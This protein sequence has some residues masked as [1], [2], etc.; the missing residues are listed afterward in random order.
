MISEVDSLSVLLAFFGIC[1][2]GIGIAV[3]L[4]MGRK[5]RLAME[6]QKKDMELFVNQRIHQ[7]GIDLKEALDGFRNILT[8]FETATENGANQTK[9]LGKE[10]NMKMSMQDEKFDET[11]RTFRTSIAK[12]EQVC[13]AQERSIIDLKRKTG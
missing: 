12:L 3:A 6:Q 4:D 5:F 2:A 9:E 11:L 10:L 1:L 7:Q 13:E 8:G